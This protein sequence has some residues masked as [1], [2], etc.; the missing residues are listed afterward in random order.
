[1]TYCTTCKYNFCWPVRTLRTQGKDGRW[2]P[3]T[4]AMAAGLVDHVWPLKEWIG[5]PAIQYEVAH[6]RRL[7]RYQGEIRWVTRAS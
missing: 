2:E 5:F 7:H 3:R 6:H 1:M 4:P